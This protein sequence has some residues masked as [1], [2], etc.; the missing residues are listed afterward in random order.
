MTDFRGVPGD[1]N[2]PLGGI[3]EI[4]GIGT[5]IEEGTNYWG[6]LHIP[7][8]ERLKT[9][10]RQGAGRDRSVTMSMFG[11]DAP[12]LG[13]CVD[14]DPQIRDLNGLPAPR[15]TYSPH[16]FEKLAQATYGPKLLDILMAA[17]AKYAALLPVGQIPATAHMT[18]T[19]RFGPDPKTSVCQP[20]GRFHDVGNLYACGGSLFPTSSGFNPT[21]TIASLAKYIAGAMIYPSSPV[22][23]LPAI[24]PT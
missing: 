16:A 6:S 18:G 20:D 12:Q 19:L 5:P 7:V 10:M 21:L 1:P 23:A 15:I 22:Q 14:L 17:G 13:N 3:I 4:G 8:G 11:E 24:P 9:M 2:R